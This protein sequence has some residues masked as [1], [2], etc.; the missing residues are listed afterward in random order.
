MEEKMV[1]LCYKLI[2]DIIPLSSPM[3]AAYAQVHEQHGLLPGLFIYI[4]P[5]GM[6]DINM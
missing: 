6:A 5:K 3:W 4:L 1:A 2:M